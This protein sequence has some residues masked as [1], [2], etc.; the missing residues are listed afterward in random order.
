MIST[1]RRHSPPLWPRAARTASS[2]DS[3]RHVHRL[4]VNTQF[5]GT[6]ALG[7][8]RAGKRRCCRPIQAARACPSRRRGTGLPVRI[9]RVFSRSH[10]IYSLPSA[11]TSGALL[12]RFYIILS[13]RFSPAANADAGRPLFGSAYTGITSRRSPPLNVWAETFCALPY[14]A[15]ALI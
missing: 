10:P 9:A 3:Y 2:A 8:A 12:S 11:G 14:S 1:I 6:L 15:G 5:C 7:R 13:S 4:P